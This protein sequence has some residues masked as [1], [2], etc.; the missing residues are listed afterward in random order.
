[1]AMLIAAAKIKGSGP[2]S[3]M[4]AFTND[5]LTTYVCRGTWIYP[6]EAHM[7]LITDMVEY[8]SQYMSPYFYPLNIQGVYFRS[9]GATQAQ[10]LAMVIADALCYVDWAI[11]RGLGIDTFAR[12]LS[13][14]F[15]CGPEIFSEA[16][17]F[18]AARRWWAGLMRERYGATEAESMRLKATAATG[19]RYFQAIEPLN[20]LVRGAYGILG[21]VMG[22]AQATFIA[23]YDEAYALPNEE[24]AMLGLRTLQI[25]QEETDLTRT[26]DPLGGSWYVE[27]LTDQIQ[28]KA[29][30]IL[31]EIQDHGGVLECIRTG[32]TRS[33][34]DA[35]LYKQHEGIQKGEI[36]LVG[37]NKYC[38]DDANAYDME[39]YVHDEEVQAAQ[40]RRL[41][42]IRSSRDQ[43]AWR[44][45][46]DSLERAVDKGENLINY[47]VEVALA[48]ASVG[49]INSVLEKHWG[50]FADP[51]T[52][53]A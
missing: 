36:A 39:L 34:L 51:N 53:V 27:S 23:G 12:R 5:I 20:N 6:P 15:S 35:C 47:L 18:R 48:H 44:K 22:G 13:F 16:A 25:L 32:W 26:I 24:S 14:F 33:Q 41:K 37:V 9:V 17:K 42:E 4:G 40:S 38:S 3:I 19:G 28:A 8:S 30:A 46:V 21:A 31:G 2:E 50:R 49:E 7:K 11:E 45:A 1:M 52:K 29:E 43:V 10:E